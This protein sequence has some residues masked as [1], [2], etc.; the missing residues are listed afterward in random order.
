[1]TSSFPAA[2]A[3]P[4]L[5]K[6]FFMSAAPTAVSCADAPNFCI[7]FIYSF[8]TL[9]SAVPFPSAACLHAVL[10]LS[11]PV[12]ARAAF[13]AYSVADSPAFLIARAISFKPFSVSPFSISS[14]PICAKSSQDFFMFR[15]VSSSRFILSRSFS[16]L[17]DNSL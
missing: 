12:L 16:D 17:S 3:C 4:I 5:L 7:E 10:K 11:T 9:F 1:M 2:A 13:C 6:P 15:I 14:I 8:T